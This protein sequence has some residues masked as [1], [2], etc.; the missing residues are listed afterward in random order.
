VRTG[1]MTL[2]V[3]PTRFS[4]ALLRGHG[5]ARFDVRVVRAD[6]ARPGC[7]RA[8]GSLVISDR[9]FGLAAGR[10]TAAVNIPRCGLSRR[11]S[12][13]STSIRPA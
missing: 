13:Q 6:G 11:W 4:V 1:T 7:L 5:L 12:S 3:R 10:S 8:L 9:S 2:K